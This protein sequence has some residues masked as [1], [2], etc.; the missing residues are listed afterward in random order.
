MQN[1]LADDVAVGLLHFYEQGQADNFDTVYYSSDTNGVAAITQTVN[2]YSLYSGSLPVMGHTLVV[3]E[4]FG[5]D[6]KSV[7]ATT[8]L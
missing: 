5:V 3:H 7:V 4:R 6:T 1:C 8:N 2:R